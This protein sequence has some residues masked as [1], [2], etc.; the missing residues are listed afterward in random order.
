[1][2]YIVCTAKLQEPVMGFCCKMLIFV[3]FTQI[4]TGPFVYFSPTAAGEEISAAADAEAAQQPRF[5]E[6]GGNSRENSRLFLSILYSPSGTARL[7]AGAD[8]PPVCGAASGRAAA[9]MPQKTTFRSRRMGRRS[10]PPPVC[11]STA[12]AAPTPALRWGW[13]PPLPAGRCTGRWR[14]RRSACSAPGSPRRGGC[15]GRSR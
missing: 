2:D 9:E 12:P 3:Y 8:T 4:R 7:P 13:S 11:G 15:G 5:G 10:G 14:R 1:M 6:Y